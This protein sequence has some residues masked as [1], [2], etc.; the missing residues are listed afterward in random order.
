[1]IKSSRKYWTRDI[2]DLI[3]QLK[4]IR[5]VNP[6]MDVRTTFTREDYTRVRES[7]SS[8]LM[9]PMLKSSTS[10]CGG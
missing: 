4:D 10:T 3:V 9:P 8:A 1:M 5:F 2:A 6:Q 7:N